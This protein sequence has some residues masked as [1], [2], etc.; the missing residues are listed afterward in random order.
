MRHRLKC[1]ICQQLDCQHR[2]ADNQHLNQRR[3]THWTSP[4]HA[5]APSK[6]AG[7]DYGV[8]RWTLGR[9]IFFVRCCLQS[10]GPRT[11]YDRFPSK[12]GSLAMFVAMRLASSSVN[13][14]DAN[15]GLTLAR[16]NISE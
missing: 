11:R 2:S 4:V 13:T 5:L 9:V 15:V 14:C 6:R 8:P 1:E 12:S 3:C 16:I 10:T 7:L